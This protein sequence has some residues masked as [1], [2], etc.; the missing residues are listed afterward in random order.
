MKYYILL[1]T[2]LSSCSIGIKQQT[3]FTVTVT[4]KIE[5]AD[6]TNFLTAIC[7]DQLPSTAEQNQ[8]QDCVSNYL[9]RFYKLSGTL[10]T[11]GT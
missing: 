11:N 7:T 2:L 10:G 3:P 1:I 8:L 6:L 5:I 9:L 4:H